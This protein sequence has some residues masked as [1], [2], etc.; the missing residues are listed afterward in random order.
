M[1]RSGVSRHQ[2]SVRDHVTSHAF[3]FDVFDDI[4]PIFIH[5]GFSTKERDV[6]FVGG[7][8]IDYFFDFLE[9]KLLPQ[10]RV[11]KRLKRAVVAPLAAHAARQV[12]FEREEPRDCFRRSAKS[13][14]QMVGRGGPYTFV[15]GSGRISGLRDRFSDV[16]DQVFTRNQSVASF[17][18]PGLAFFVCFRMISTAA[19][20][21]G[22]GI[23]GWTGIKRIRSDIVVALGK[24]SALVPSQISE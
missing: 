6:G 2:R 23:R 9:S 22:R 8:F 20:S 17:V 18:V 3:A 13:V 4:S 5:H 12:A 24:G 14:E 10:Y 1:I 11:I 21:A 15:C 19:T 16:S 7:E